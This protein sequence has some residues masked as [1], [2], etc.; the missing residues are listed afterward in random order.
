MK[1]IQNSLQLNLNTFEIRCDHNLRTGHG[2]KKLFQPSFFYSPTFSCLYLLP[3]YLLLYFKERGEYIFLFVFLLSNFLSFY[4]YTLL[5]F[6]PLFL[7]LSVFLFLPFKPILFIST[8]H[9]L[10]FVS[11]F[12]THHAFLFYYSLSSSFSLPLLY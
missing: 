5:F 3:F 1:I 8:I 11:F 9:P 4:L 6:F 12:F 7:L 2:L 10:L